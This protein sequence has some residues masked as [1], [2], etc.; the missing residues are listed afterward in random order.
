M[1]FIL[2][3]IIIFALI[4]AFVSPFLCY[5][6]SRIGLKTCEKFYKN[7]VISLSCYQKKSNKIKVGVK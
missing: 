6:L 2:T 7:F 1:G 4:V 5:G 3:F